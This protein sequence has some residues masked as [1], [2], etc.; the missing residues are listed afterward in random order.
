MGRN[1]RDGGVTVI[2]HIAITAAAALAA[3]YVLGRIRP[4]RRLLA[5]AEERSYG[6]H[7]PAWWA[8]QAIGLVA[9]AWMV[10]VHPRRSAANRR[11]WREARNQ[12]RSP[13]IAI[14]RIRRA[15]APQFDPDWAA[16][17][18]AEPRKEDQ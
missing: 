16:N 18:G 17:R 15:P 14:P 3:G 4:G 9:V 1:Y 6:P 8:A 10:T 7:G 13:A 5:W 11:S 2:L 12:K